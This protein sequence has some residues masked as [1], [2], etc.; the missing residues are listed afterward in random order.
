MKHPI[1]PAAL[2]AFFAL[3]FCSLFNLLVLAQE[4]N[5][6]GSG[7]GSENA[8]STTTTKTTSVSITSDHT[9]ANWYTSPWVWIVGAAV[10][11]LLLVAL[12]GN[13]NRDTVH[14]TKTVEKNHG[15]D[16]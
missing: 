16:S 13:R 4:N 1:K 11:I 5:A 3:V 14:V 10:F 6:G 7:G 2:K 15:H 12:L 9:N 8:T